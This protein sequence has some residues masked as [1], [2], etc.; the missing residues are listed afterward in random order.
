[1]PSSVPLPTLL[2]IAAHSSSFL[3]EIDLKHLAELTSAFV[4]ALA[5]YAA[6]E[7][8]ALP[9]EESV[10]GGRTTLEGHINVTGLNRLD[11]EGSGGFTEDALD[12]L[13]AKVRPSLFGLP[14]AT[15]LIQRFGPTRALLYRT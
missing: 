8:M 5:L 13:F 3:R 4:H 14:L 11:L 6:G 10:G 12:H 9:G 15:S 1:M 2:T 7:D